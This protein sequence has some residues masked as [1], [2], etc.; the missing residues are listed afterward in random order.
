M[1][2]QPEHDLLRKQLLYRSWHRGCKETDLLLGRFANVHLDGFNDL[3]LQHYEAL[4]RCDDWDIFAWLTG[5]EPVPANLDNG[6]MQK[7]LAFS[8]AEHEG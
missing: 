6:V 1:T 3:E 2:D 7:L 5:K 4:L 8:F